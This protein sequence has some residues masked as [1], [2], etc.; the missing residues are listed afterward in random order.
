MKDV[1]GIGPVQAAELT[2][3]TAPQSG[4]VSMFE[5]LGFVPTQRNGQAGVVM[6]FK[7]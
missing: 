2:P 3:R 7:V 4:L 1:P 5:R 6:R